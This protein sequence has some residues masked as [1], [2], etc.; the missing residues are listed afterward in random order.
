MNGGDAVVIGAT[1]AVAACFGGLPLLLGG[2]GVAYAGKKYIEHQMLTTDSAVC[3]QQ[4]R[5]LLNRLSNNPSQQERTR[6]EA[7]LDA[8]NRGVSCPGSQAGREIAG[9]LVA[10][11]SLINPLAGIAAIGGMLTGRR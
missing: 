4:R 7:E 1:V 11:G 3:D 5:A 2:A 8:V 6:L 10:V 9:V